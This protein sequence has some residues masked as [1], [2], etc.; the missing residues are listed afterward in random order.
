M[1]NIF[2]RIINFFNTSSPY[3]NNFDVK[4]FL[5]KS[6]FNNSLMGELSSEQRKYSEYNY[7]MNR[8]VYLY[9]LAEQNPENTDKKLQAITNTFEQAKNM[10]QRRKEDLKNKF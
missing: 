6:N 9:I 4:K 10:L 7:I 1:K 2:K 8:L 3:C 5:E